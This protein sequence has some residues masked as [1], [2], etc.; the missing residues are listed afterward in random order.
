[1]DR[2][3][4]VVGGNSGISKSLVRALSND[5]VVVATSRTETNIEYASQALKFEASSPDQLDLSSL[6]Y[7]DGLVYCPG[8]INLKPFKS[9]KIKDFIK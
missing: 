5:S 4:L 1:M 3:I 2:K 6:E 7:L 8:S 9:L